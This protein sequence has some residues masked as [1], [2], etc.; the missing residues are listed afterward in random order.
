MFVH[1]VFSAVIESVVE[2]VESDAQQD[3]ELKRS[4][5]ARLS[6]TKE[7]YDESENS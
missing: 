1:F 3:T 6:S 7:E 5:V 4:L 2:H